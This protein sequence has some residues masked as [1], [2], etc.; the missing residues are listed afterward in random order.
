MPKNNSDWP[1]ARLRRPVSVIL[2]IEF[3]DDLNLDRI[4]TPALRPGPGVYTFFAP[5]SVPLGTEPRLVVR[6]IRDGMNLARHF[7]AGIDGMHG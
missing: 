4:L 2:D 6:P 3:L 1:L 7:S 5:L